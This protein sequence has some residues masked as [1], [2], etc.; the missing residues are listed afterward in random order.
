MTKIE[1]ILVGVLVGSL[2]AYLCSRNWGGASGI[3][4]IAFVYAVY[5]AYKYWLAKIIR[6]QG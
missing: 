2:V 5:A 1:L 4:G 3:G 6:R